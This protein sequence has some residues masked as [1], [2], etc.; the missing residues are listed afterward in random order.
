[1]AEL[2]G[3]ERETL[4]VDVVIV[5]AG[6]AGLAA[7]YKLADLIRAHNESSAE[8]KL[9]GISIAVLEKGKEIGSH[10]ISGAVMD[11]RGIT[12]LMPDWLDRGCPVEAPV[13]SDAFWYLTE[14][15]NVAAPIM[16]PPLRNHGNYVISLGE[17][18]RWLGP[19][20]GEMG[21]DLFAE[22][23]ASRVLVENGRVV[24]VR[25]G[26]KGIDKNG[27]PKA[28]YE[29]G[30][31]VK[32]KVTI[33]AEGP[34]GT[35]TKQLAGM[36]D[37]YAGKNPQV[38]S[39][40]VKELWQLPDDR[41]PAG[42]VIHTLGFPLDMDTFGGGFI[43]GMKDRIVDIGLVVGLDYR[44]P[45]T[46]PHDLLQ[47]MKLHPAIKEIL[48]GGKMIS[49]GAKAIPEGGYFSMPKLYGDGF[50]ILG[51]SGGFLN[52]ARLKGIH[53]AIKSGILAAETAF[54][55]L[56]NDD[57]SANHLKQY[58]ELFEASWAKEELWKQR[59]FHQAFNNGQLAGI[60]NAGLGIVTGGR[61]FGVANK[62]EG[63]EGYA[64]MERIKRYY[65]S[66]DPHPPGK[67][68]YDN[69]YTFDKV[70]NVYNGG[71]IHEE[72][73]PAHLLIL[74]TE[75][76]ITR[77]TEEYGNP[78][79]HFCP[80]QVYEP[81]PTPDGRGRVPFLNFTNCFHCKTCDIMDPYQVITWVP[82]EGGG[83]PDYKKL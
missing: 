30:V 71:V 43:Y 60:V 67:V 80:A 5:G 49:A 13:S 68:K 16:P 22:F 72:N 32:A 27:Q 64:R 28:N 14:T 33:F 59:N 7:A 1:M 6:P 74:D 79:F 75:V 2:P 38:Y 53:L 40:G 34:R 52:G 56:L 83:G 57:F 24:G 20:V 69:S 19:I 63:H 65:G 29:P 51:D 36:F 26:D 44:N 8:K 73:Q 39:V 58:D 82:P 61:G 12:E 3:I 81:Q 15:M 50:M 76:C 55:A 46:D 45:T 48:Q 47:R 25:T 35:C 54:A 70:T 10:G 17:M 66:D 77:C 31:D 11:P 41:F 23:A 78:C 37:L 9:E 18:V 21:V 4:D 42:S 62:L